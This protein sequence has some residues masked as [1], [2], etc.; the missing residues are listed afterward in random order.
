MYSLVLIFNFTT[1][2]LFSCSYSIK[3]GE[4]VKRRK[5]FSVFWLEYYEILDQPQRPPQSCFRM[6]PLYQIVGFWQYN[7]K[8]LKQSGQV[9]VA[10]SWY[11]GIID[12]ILIRK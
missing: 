12:P 11:S 1:L 3:I 6:V 4:I 5:K 9:L 10:K 8:V 7:T 2:F